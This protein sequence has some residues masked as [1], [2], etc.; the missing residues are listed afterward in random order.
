[1][2]EEDADKAVVGGGDRPASSG[3]GYVSTFRLLCL[4]ATES[5]MR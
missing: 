1:M 2:M 3:S 5:D 4:E